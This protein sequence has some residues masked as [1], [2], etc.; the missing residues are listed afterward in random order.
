MF[1]YP[2]RRILILK[3]RFLTKK[4]DCLIKAV[5]SQ[6]LKIIYLIFRFQTLN[7]Y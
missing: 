7:I 6:K 4:K 1:L 5:Y 3:L 2:M